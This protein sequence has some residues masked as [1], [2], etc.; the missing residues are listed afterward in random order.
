M[1]YLQDKWQKKVEKISEMISKVDYKSHSTI[2]E[3]MYLSEKYNEALDKR[4]MY[5]R[6]VE[7]RAAKKKYGI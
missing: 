1:K 7:T 4:N 3:R 5:R 6:W 2:Y